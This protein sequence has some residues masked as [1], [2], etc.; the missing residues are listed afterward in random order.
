M[1]LQKKLYCYWKLH[2]NIVAMVLLYDIASSIIQERITTTGYLLK[3]ISL[4]DDTDQV[5]H[6][7]HFVWGWASKFDLIWF[8][9][10]KKSEQDKIQ[11][12]VQLLSLEI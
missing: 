10:G 4:C 3:A 2:V 7:N 6:R 8:E 9:Q 5:L 1:A 12:E 11:A